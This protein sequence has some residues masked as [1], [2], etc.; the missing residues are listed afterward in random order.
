MAEFLIDITLPDELEDEFIAKIPEQRLMVNKLLAKGIVLSYSL[1]AD[2]TKLWITMQA[3]S[4]QEII[5]QLNIFPL[6]DY[7]T[8]KIHLLAFHNSSAVQIP[9]FS[10]N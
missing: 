5:R 3:D 9:P 8:Y 1:S 7:F 10:L 4:R 6:I 2:R